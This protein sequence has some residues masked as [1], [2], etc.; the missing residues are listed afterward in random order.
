MELTD[1]LTHPLFISFEGGEGAGKTTQIQRFCQWL[2]G[3]DVILF[4]T[5]QPGGTPTGQ[6]IR[7][8]LLEPHNDEMDGVTEALLFAADR[9]LALMTNI[10]PALK[11]GTT[12]VTDRYADSTL[13]YQTARGANPADIQA[14]HQQ[15]TCGGVMPHITFIL[16]ID[17]TIGVQRS[18]RRLSASASQETRY[19]DMDLIF[20][21]KVRE[22][23]L[24]I[25]KQEPDRCILVDAN[26]RPE[27]VEEKIQQAFLERIR[28][29]EIPP[30]L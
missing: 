3:Q 23:F 14:L 2:K 8:I 5:K 24:E 1:L 19:E 28:D 9:R 29:M 7:H 27:E 13:V 21:R 22:G 6:K 10:L 20:H 16:D 26:R 4:A 30:C 11:Q 25:A 18:H 17:P 15:A 12:V